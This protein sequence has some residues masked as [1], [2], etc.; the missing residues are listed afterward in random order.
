MKSSPKILT[1]ALLLA[2]LQFALISCVTDAYVGTGVYYGPHYRDPWFHD[3]PWMDGHRSYYDRGYYDR[4]YYDR[5]G[6]RADVY[7]AP[8]PVR[9]PPPPRIR[10]P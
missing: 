5:G 2:G 1:A 8:P 3:G 10:L 4:G 7:I 9:L 6:G